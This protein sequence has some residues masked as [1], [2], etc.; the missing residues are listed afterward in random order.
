MRRHRAAPTDA[1]RKRVAR[2]TQWTWG[3]ELR[4]YYEQRNQLARTHEHGA[5]ADVAD[6][7]VMGPRARDRAMLAVLALW[8]QRGRLRTPPAIPEGDRARIEAW[9]A[10]ADETAVS[11]LYRD[12]LA[13]ARD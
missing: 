7:S 1:S 9:L 5:W 8:G 11:R 3:E 10:E 2:F 4:L 6:L 12:L 13:E